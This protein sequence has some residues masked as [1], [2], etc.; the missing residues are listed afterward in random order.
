MVMLH[1]QWGNQNQSGTRTI[2]EAI[3]DLN[4]ALRWLVE[5]IAT[6]GVSPIMTKHFSRKTFPTRSLDVATHAHS[7]IKI[8]SLPGSDPLFG[9]EEL[10]SSGY[11]HKEHWL[12]NTW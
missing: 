10:V 8:I 4:V 11:M 1:L 9:N 2:N 5:S 3:W 7:D 12:P 6:R